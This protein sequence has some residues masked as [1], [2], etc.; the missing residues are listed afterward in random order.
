M[1]SIEKDNSS[2]RRSRQKLLSV[3]LMV[4][5]LS[6]SIVPVRAL[7]QTEEADKRQQ[8]EEVRHRTQ[9]E[10][11]DRQEREQ[12]KDT[13]LQSREKNGQETTLPMETP[14]F[15]IYTLILEGDRVNEF[16]WLQR[17]LPVYQE[18]HIGKE[19]INRDC[20]TPDQCFN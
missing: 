18:K 3:L 11:A 9:Q 10:A 17:M 2:L 12:K 16:P 8:Q 7:C 4:F 5:I 13:F 19:G 6:A 1:Q 14:R 15:L 20:E